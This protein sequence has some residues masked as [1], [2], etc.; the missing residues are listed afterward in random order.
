LRV[1]AVDGRRVCSVVDEISAVS[2]RPGMGDSSS[3]RLDAVSSCSTIW[4]SPDS[5]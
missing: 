5:V 3:E 4:G 1:A 2:D